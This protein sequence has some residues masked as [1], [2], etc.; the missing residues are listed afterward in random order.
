MFDEASKPDGA[1]K[2]S[3]LIQGKDGNLYG[4]TFGG[5]GDKPGKLFKI[6]L[7]KPIPAYSNFLSL[8]LD[9]FLNF[10]H[11][12]QA[13]NGSFYGVGLGRGAFAG[14]EYLFKAQP[15]ISPPLYSELMA[16]PTYRSDAIGTSELLQ[17][18]GDKFYA[19]M[20]RGGDV[21]DIGQGTRSAGMIVQINAA[22]L[23]PS[24]QVKVLH[25]F[26]FVNGAN[27][28]SGLIRG[29]DGKLYGTTC[30]SGAVI[31]GV[32]SPNDYGVIYSF[33]LTKVTPVYRVLHRFNGTNGGCPQGLFQSADGKLYGTTDNG[34][35]ANQGVIFSLD[36]T[37]IQACLSGLA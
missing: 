2:P 26:N 30:S 33:D 5:F 17:G 3:W 19:T 35:S 20:S 29:K 21:F 32:V 24:R 12:I 22:S 18:N 36:I 31:N 4:S 8:G 10:N 27:P 28:S 14:P 11:F 23:D 1:F 15:E 13:R 34:G 6:D 16:L 7:A 37:K 9:N 25:K